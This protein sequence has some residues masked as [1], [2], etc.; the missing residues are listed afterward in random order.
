[1]PMFYPERA[2][3]HP[4][5]ELQ[6]T[7]QTK[8]GQIGIYLSKNIYDALTF[9]KED[10]VILGGF[11]AADGN[12]PVVVQGYYEVPDDH[13]V[14]SMLTIGDDL[15][16]CHA[17]NDSALSYSG[18]PI[19]HDGY[20]YVA[21]VSQD[22][23]KTK[24]YLESRYPDYVLLD[25]EKYNGDLLDM[26]NFNILF[27]VIL[28]AG[29]LLILLYALFFNS[30][31]V[32]DERT[33]AIYRALGLDKKVIFV[34]CLLDILKRITLFFTIPYILIALG[35][36]GT[37]LAVSPLIHFL[38]ILSTYGIVLIAVLVPLLLLLSMTPHQLL[39]K[40]DV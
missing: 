32:Q 9:Q 18:Y 16:Y 4:E 3:D 40:K 19:I 14:P 28:L 23:K 25:L 8:E 33:I 29:L 1:M 10:D 11:S 13:D 20:Y 22:V 7:H 35:L 17:I 27:S 15:V 2:E 12:A 26:S 30:R 5:V 39:L 36:A 31:L 34:H 24:A 38:T 21:L 6:E 37:S